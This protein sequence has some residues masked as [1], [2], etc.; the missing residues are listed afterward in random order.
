MMQERQAMVFLDGAR[1]I[2]I[3]NAFIR[4]FNLDLWN[5]RKDDYK[6]LLDVE[7]KHYWDAWDELLDRAYHVDESGIKWTLEQDDN[8]YAIKG[9]SIHA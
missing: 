6:E 9:D 4:G 8:L 3:P 1:G 7:H 2:Y 5:I